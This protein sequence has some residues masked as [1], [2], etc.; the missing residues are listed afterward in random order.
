MGRHVLTEDGIETTM[1]VNFLAPF[2]L[3]GLL[4][5]VLERNSPARVVNVASVMHR[6]GEIRWDDLGGADPDSVR[7]A[8]RRSKLA[9]VMFT[10]EL[11]RRLAG[12]GVTA[13]AVCPGGVATRIWR[14]APAPVR[15]A[16]GLLLKP[17]PEGARLPVWVASAP[18]LEAVSG[19]YFEVPV[20]FRFAR[21]DERRTMVPP[22]P[23][24]LVDGD[25]SRLWAEAE[26]ITG[27]NG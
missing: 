7:G 5:P 25:C 19:E 10:R 14:D 3:T 27:R 2:L 22:A 21:W 13:N 24:A 12:T 18:D 11:A 4:L 6:R 9:L 16:M 8:Y 20:H 1:A 17:A 15:A 26:R 23:A